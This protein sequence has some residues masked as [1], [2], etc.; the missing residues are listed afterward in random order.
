MNVN[1]WCLARTRAEQPAHMRGQT[2]VGK[3]STLQRTA[4]MAD[5]G[6]AEEVRTLT[7]R[8]S[9]LSSVSQSR[10]RLTRSWSGASGGSLGSEGNGGV[11]LPPGV[12]PPSAT[13]VRQRQ[14]IA[15]RPSERD[16]VIKSG[17]TSEEVAATRITAAARGYTARRAVRVQ[18]QEVA[19]KKAKEEREQAEAATK[20]ASVVKGRVAR[21]QVSQLREVERRRVQAA[22]REEEARATKAAADA[23]MREAAL[24]E[25][26]EAEAKAALARRSAEFDAELERA[27]S[28]VQERDAQLA[29]LKGN[30]A[31]QT[32]AAASKDATISELRIR[33]KELE[34][35]LAHREEAAKLLQDDVA[36][37]RAREA[38]LTLTLKSLQRPATQDAC[39]SARAIDD[40]MFL[41]QR[42]A[43]IVR[44]EEQIKMLTGRV[45]SLMGGIDKVEDQVTLM[46]TQVFRSDEAFAE[47]REEAEELRTEVL[48]LNALL[49]EVSARE[50]AMDAATKQNADL[51]KVL[52]QTEVQAEEVRPPTP[53]RL[54]P[55]HLHTRSRS[56]SRA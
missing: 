51:L 1:Q 42:D 56:H 7:R 49:K 41:Q 15:M 12:R 54:P 30:L 16:I 9:E 26:K 18:R 44:Q 31:K 27:H 13:R 36:D 43:I 33:V 23:A 22:A 40:S 48:R 5:A 24:R 34:A 2:G 53:P 35:E 32:A 19:T 39:L 55:C 20:I 38:K 14:G 4:P 28:V 47:K 11:A 46:Q 25:Q 6:D 37:G 8:D 3:G 10:R 50:F 52:M 45:D 29:M 17:P 21:R